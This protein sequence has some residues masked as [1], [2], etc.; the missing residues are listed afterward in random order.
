MPAAMRLVDIVEAYGKDFYDLR[1]HIIHFAVR[2]GARRMADAAAC[3]L[4]IG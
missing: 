1:S 2:V 4:R 3:L